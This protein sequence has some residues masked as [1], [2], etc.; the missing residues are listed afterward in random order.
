MKYHNSKGQEVEISEMPDAY[1]L[2]AYAKQKRRLEV[3]EKSPRKSLTKYYMVELKNLL[4]EFKKEIHQ[5][6]LL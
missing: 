3:L 5:R 6:N 2:N 1:L 4:L